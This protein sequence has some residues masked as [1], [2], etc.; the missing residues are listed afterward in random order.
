MASAKAMTVR[1]LINTTLATT[2]AN[3]TGTWGTNT[4]AASNQ[5]T[6]TASNT[7]EAIQTD[8][9]TGCIAIEQ[10]SGGIVTDEEALHITMNPVIARGLARSYEYKQ[11][12]KGSPDA[13]AAITDQRNPNRRYG[14]APYLYGLALTVENAVVVTTPKFANVASGRGGVT[15]SYVWP[16]ANVVICSKPQGIVQ[17]SEQ[18][19]DFST[20]CMRFYEMM[21]VESKD[22]PDNRRTVG[23]VV[24]DWVATLQAPQTGYLFT[25]I[26]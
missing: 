24:E 8:I 13:L 1:T 23:R 7:N 12:I 10:A 15:R 20:F 21:T 25:S 18:T 5:W 16:N 26:S 22:D 2:A 11:Y 19:L 14:M 3:W 9:N 17:E 4:S 6:N